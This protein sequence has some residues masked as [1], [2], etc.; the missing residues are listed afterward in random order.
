MHEHRRVVVLPLSCAM[1]LLI[2]T[3]GRLKQ[4]PERDLAAA[5]HERAE[6]T[7]R[8]LT[9]AGGARELSPRGAEPAVSEGRAIDRG[10]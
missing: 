8:S 6:A 1:R 2:A 7:G 3:V 4:G 9:W 10:T 5:Y